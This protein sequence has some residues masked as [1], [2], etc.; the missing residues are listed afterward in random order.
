MQTDNVYRATAPT[1]GGWHSFESGPL[2]GRTV[3]VSLQELQKAEHGRKYASSFSLAPAKVVSSQ[4]VL[5]VVTMIWFR[6]GRK[7]KRPLDPPPV[8]QV[9]CYQIARQ[10][11]AEQ[12][13]REFDTYDEFLTFGLLCQVDLFVEVDDNPAP[14]SST[15]QP[16]P[17]QPSIPNPLNGTQWPTP[18][19][20]G[21]FSNAE[22]SGMPYGA[23]VPAMPFDVRAA[24]PDYARTVDLS[25]NR[26]HDTWNMRSKPYMAPSTASPFGHQRY[27]DENKCTEL[28]SGETV[29][30]CSLVEYGGRKAAMFAFPD[31]AVKKEGRFVFRYRAFN[32]QSKT[33]D[34]GVVSILAECF[35]G[36][37]EVYSTKSFPGLQA[38]TEL[39]RRLSLSGV[40]LNSRQKERRGVKRGSRGGDSDTNSSPPRSAPHAALT[41]RAATASVRKPFMLS[42]GPGVAPYTSSFSPELP[43]SHHASSASGT[44]VPGPTAGPS[45]VRSP[46]AL[47]AWTRIGGDGADMRGGDSCSTGTEEEGSTH[48]LW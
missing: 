35:G 41:A 11:S 48:S 39:T 15:R 44:V 9:K 42:T 10:G 12:A 32:I 28:L 31:L 21:S 5:I 26:G 24:R 37:F 27:S 18:V 45:R 38:S 36:P 34:D 7:D 22:S 25:T 6:Y 13:G 3:R 23:G 30:P 43:F 40:R 16:Y 2:A 19:P 1:V 14:A 46:V 20:R 17:F 47:L 33:R 8:V 4:S 29:V